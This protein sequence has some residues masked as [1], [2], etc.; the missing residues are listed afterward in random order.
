MSDTVITPNMLPV[1]GAGDVSDKAKVFFVVEDQQ[2]TSPCTKRMSEET[3]ESLIPTAGGG[4]SIEGVHWVDDVGDLATLDPDDGDMVHTLGYTVVGDGGHRSVCY[5]LSS[6]ATVDGVLVF[7]GPGSVG[8]YLA[9]DIDGVVRP[10][11]GGCAGNGLSGSPTDDWARMVQVVA[12]GLT[13]DVT[14]GNFYLSDKITLSTAGQEI[15]GDHTGLLIQGTENKP[16]FD[17]TANKVRISGVRF[18]GKGASPSPDI[19]VLNIAIRAVNIWGLRITKCQIENF[20]FQGIYLQGCKVCSV[21]FCD[22]WGSITVSHDSSADITCWGNSKTILILGNHCR[23][24]AD[25]GINVGALQNDRDIIIIA[26]QVITTDVNGAE[27]TPTQRRRCIGLHYSTDADELNYIICT[28]NNCIGSL[29]AGIYFNGWGGSVIIGNNTVRKC[30]I[31]TVDESLSGGIAVL[32]SCRSIIISH[33]DVSDV[34]SD[35]VGAINIYRDSTGGTANLGSILVEGN[36]IHDS[37][38]FGISILGSTARIEISGNNITNCTR[39]L[40]Y[41][42]SYTVLDAEMISITGNTMQWN[43][44]T[45]CAVWMD[46][47]GGTN[48]VNV[49]GNKMVYTGTKGTLAANAGI[50]SQRMNLK[51]H[52]NHIKGCKSGVYFYVGLTGRDITADVDFNTF[53]DLDVVCVG[54]GTTANTVMFIG[55][56]NRFDNCA[57]VGD[58][59]TFYNAVWIGQI[60]RVNSQVIMRLSATPAAG[61]WVTGDTVYFTSPAAAGNIGTVYTSSGWKTFGAIAA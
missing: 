47:Q 39:H 41:I 52:H 5:S 31:G 18:K 20:A 4:T 38:S 21:T 42:A 3:L 30:S 19:N 33:N 26:N 6:T 43:T 49:S 27:I 34:T 9:C 1:M 45:V 15:R 8:R 29:N 13:V 10:T 51:A 24:D 55:A 48:L 54:R 56:N 35:A 61:T 59:D 46:T 58:G 2:T 60:D 36:I 40:V 32:G 23:S 7:N 17:V 57:A 12:T 37:A 25:V 28:D 50:Y 53:E 14:G 44:A 22:I 16:V 11:Q